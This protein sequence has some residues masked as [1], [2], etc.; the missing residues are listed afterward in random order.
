MRNKKDWSARLIVFIAST[1]WFYLLAQSRL[2]ARDEG[3]Y[4]MAAQLVAGGKHPYFD[5]FYPQAPWY[6]Y[7]LAL[8]VELVGA[9]WETIRISSVLLGGVSAVLVFAITRARTTVVVA[10][11]TAVLFLCSSFIFPWIVLAK[12]YAAALCFMLLA[13]VLMSNAKRGGLGLAAGV[14][15]GFAGGVRLYCLALAPLGLWWY[16]ADP[17][18]R[19]SFHLGLAL[20]LVPFALLLILD[21]DLVWFNNVQYHFLRTDAGFLDTL[22]KR[23]RILENVLGL[24]T[25]PGFSP[26]HFGPLLVG[27]LL[28]GWCS[29]RRPAF[30]LT[31]AFVGVLSIVSLVPSPPYEQYFVLVLPF[32]LIGVATAFHD[33]CSCIDNRYFKILLGLVAISY[34]AVALAPVPDLIDRYIVSGEGVRGVRSKDNAPSWSP[35]TLTRIAAEIDAVTAPGEVVL[36]HWP[37]HLLGT[38]ALPIAGLENHFGLRIGH[39]LTPEQRGSYKV[40]NYTE[41]IRALSAPGSRTAILAP[42]A[43]RRYYGKALEEHNYQMVREIGGISIYQRA[44]TQ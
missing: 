8:S 30:K 29:L 34:T 26:W 2:I 7:L 38:S 6:P 25:N 17:V 27:L 1:V 3:F 44:P 15:L 12:P 19:R 22:P 14:M 36:A 43:V 21:F 13:Y 37:G 10:S 18:Q 4:A 31:L 40:L 9:S 23:A 32:L 41:A 42:L 28:F 35:A 24:N 20:A 11:F 5:F 33:C 39:K 16:R